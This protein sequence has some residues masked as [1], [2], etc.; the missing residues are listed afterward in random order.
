MSKDIIG[1]REERKLLKKRLSSKEAEFIAL[2]GRRRVGK[3]YLIKHAIEDVNARCIEV[4]GLK[5]G[6]LKDQL[7]IFM[8]AFEKTFQPAFPIATPT[9]W[10]K[11]FDMLTRAIDQLPKAKSF[12]IFLDELPW[13][14]T[15]KSGLLQALD[16]FWN[17]E[18]VNRPRI[19]LFVCGSAASWI[20]DNIVN[21]TGGLHNRLTASIRLKPFTIEETAEYL[22]SR[23]VKLKSEQVLD[24][25][26]VMG[27]IPFYL[28]AVEKGLSAAQNINQ[29][30]FTGG[31][32]L[33]EE[34]NRLYS[35]LFKNSEA[36][37]KIIRQIAKKPHGIDQITLEKEMKLSSSG[38]TLTGR[39][40]EL[41]AA[42]FVISF[43][44]YGHAKKGIYYRIIDEYTLFYLRWIEPVANRIKLASS[45]ANYW[46]SK[47]LTAPW[48]SWV[49]NAFEAFCYKHIDKIARALKISTGFTVGTWR[50]IAKSKEDRG[51]Q[52]DLLLDRDDGV[53]SI[54]EIK[55]SQ[56]PFRITKQYATE[57]GDKI[58]IFKEQLGIKKEVFLAMITLAGLFQ[59]EYV[60]QLVTNE[61]TLEDL[62][63]DP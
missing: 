32:L 57:L 17:T 45:Q 52:I 1:R 41:E 46:Q 48:K 11:A 20:L 63:T 23:S 19:K 61:L 25:Y 14:A 40:N 39:L 12:V 3:T 16:H 18:W 27:G 58:D 9:S 10:I 15:P 49:G 31:G 26:L 56:T 55:Y 37:I 38:G 35:S 42:G 54:F 24:L 30:C 28:K 8:R 2:Y 59:N 34:F 60:D 50:Y 21:A 33:Y 44:P 53:I 62:L 6:T 7:D 5:D 4:T 29:L 47:C 51:A 36:Y 43:V 22:A 13:L